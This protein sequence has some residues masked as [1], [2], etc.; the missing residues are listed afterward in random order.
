MV[1]KIETFYVI[2]DSFDEAAKKV[3]DLLDCWDWHFSDDRTV[4]NIKVLA[5]IKQFD[6][7]EVLI[8]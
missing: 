7:F 4:E 6:P 3:K 2:A 5:S 1:K 8:L